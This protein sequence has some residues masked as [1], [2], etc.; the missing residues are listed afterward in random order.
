[1]AEI[2]P[3]TNQ[4][5]SDPLV[6][7][8]FQSKAE[9]EKTDTGK[10]ILKA[11]F[12]QQ[13]SNQ[14]DLNFFLGRKARWMEI[15]LWAKGSQNQQEFLNYMDVSDGNKSYVQLDL[16]QQRIG[17]QFIGTLVES[18]AKNRTYPCVK[19][20]DAGSL[21]EKEQ[22]KWDALYRMY[23]KEFIDEAQQLTGIQLEPP[24]AYI[25][26]DELSAR[27]YFELEDQLPKEIKFELLLNRL[28]NEIKF[29]K[30]LNRKGL[31]DLIA[32][33]LEAT[34]IERLAPK[35]Y[36]VRKCIPTNMVYNFFM[37][38]SGDLEV[39]LIGEFYSLKVKDIREKFG[40]SESNPEGL[41]EEQIF[42]LAKESTTKNIGTFNYTWNVMW[43]YNT[44]NEARPYDDC[45]VL[46]LDAEIDCGEEVYY[47]TKKDAYGKENIQQKKG[48]PYQ[49]RKADGT[50]INQPK[51]D[52][53]EITRKKKTSWMR[54]VY[55]P[56]SDVMLY[57]G[58]P[59]VIITPYT[60]VNKS[61]SS[62]SIVIPNNDG[63]Y[64][65]SLFERIME[66]LREYSITK[67]KRK[68][69]I[70]LVKPSGITIDVES[71]RN[72]DLGNGDSI[73]WEEVVRIYNQTGNQLWSSKGINPN[74]QSSPPISVG[75]QDNTIQKI[76]ELT[77]VL[78]SIVAEIRQLIG[79]PQ[80]R[81]GS[82]VG[83]RTS[84]VLQEQQ[85]I[86][87]YNVTDFILNAHNQLW[88]ETYHK[89][90]LLHWNDIVREEPESS[91]DMLN[92]RFETS[93]KMKS[94]E[95]QKQILEQDIQRYSQML[96]GQG[97]PLLTPK[98]AMMLREIDN[99]KLAR[100]YM[101]SV[102]E[103]N[104]R[105]AEDRSARLQE[106]NAAVQKESMM[107]AEEMKQK[108][109]EAELLIKVKQSEAE[110]Q[111]KKQQILL[112][113]IGQ[114]R[115]KGVEIPANWLAVEKE[116]LQNIQMGLF[117]ENKETES[118]VDEGIQQAQ[119][120]QQI[121]QQEQPQMV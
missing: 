30:V 73:A 20:V 17:P 35:C 24:N 80:Y 64:V 43:G 11:F 36:T 68:Q 98:D 29:E 14:T 1:M 52:D 87:S 83:D 26:D 10:K 23:D 108:A 113:K 40:R 90:C 49:T 120:E 50:I 25:P 46:A 8:L 96:D 32:T 21:S 66:P 15:L 34:K 13:T 58:R 82:D 18:M 112:E 109:L 33:N 117:I 6:N 9:L 47:V 48:I 91:S 57:W 56:Y 63:D 89:I 86:S 55:V 79:V 19:A 100:W 16:T 92:T 77:N 69:L 85:N 75:V 97:N 107:A 31:Y 74:E 39:T 27:V 3:S 78:G 41:T 94:T 93:I 111:E 28:N 2:S 5:F 59:D 121:M 45:N 42:K 72:L 38:D 119:Q 22:R 7:R 51:P 101:V 102:L 116:L 99:D 71:A 76:V 44:Y 67:L 84:G 62:Y 4:Q 105:E 53:V 88:E 54:G 104:K 95:A 106:Q 115:E 70:A 110:G 118:A 103:K 61:F 12:A 114:L 81:D 65:P 60:Q 37:N